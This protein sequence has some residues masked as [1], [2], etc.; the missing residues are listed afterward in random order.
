MSLFPIRIKPGGSITVHLRMEAS[1]PI[2]V[3]RR[4][5][6]VDP[7]GNRTL[8]YERLL[9]FVPPPTKSDGGNSMQGRCGQILGG[10]PLLMAARYL[11]TA[12]ENSDLF[13]SSLEGLRD[14]THHYYNLKIPDDAPLGRYYFELEDRGNGNLWQS[15]TAE[16]DFFYV[17]QIYLERIL[18]KE[19]RYEA[20][21]NN[22]SPES[23]LVQL[24]QFPDGTEDEMSFE[25]SLIT[26]PPKT[27]SSVSFRGAALLMYR[28]G[29][30]I[31][32]LSK[33]D[34]VF[35]LRNPDLK[36]MSR[37]ESTFVFK[38]KTQPEE[39][40]QLEGTSRSIWFLANGFCPRSLVRNT[41]N[42]SVY[43]EMLGLQLILE[44]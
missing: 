28:D 21:L 15:Q 4:D 40:F 16:G 13:L 27:V 42:A 26:L 14:A 3:K 18:E 35:C 30:E 43:D 25:S 1:F 32:R 5:F 29:D 22:P 24:I 39:A 7:N 33:E 37:G 20:Q 41:D 11:Q 19:N 2:W 36:F 10:A 9:P 34:H 44:I 31:I 8:V 38:N 23:T 17:E 6:L 12:T